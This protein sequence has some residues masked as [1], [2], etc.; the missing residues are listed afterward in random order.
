VQPTCKRASL[1]C[2]SRDRDSRY[3]L[4]TPGAVR[5]G[6]R[7]EPLKRRRGVTS[8]SGDWRVIGSDPGQST[9]PVLTQERAFFI[10]GCENLFQNPTI[11]SL[12]Q[13]LTGASNTSCQAEREL[14]WHCAQEAHCGDLT[15]KRRRG[16]LKRKRR[17][18]LRDLQEM[19]C[20][21]R[22]GYRRKNRA[23]AGPESFTCKIGDL[24]EV[25]GFPAGT[26]PA[27]RLCAR[28][29]ALECSSHR[30]L[31]SIFR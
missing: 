9:D 6:R 10:P 1:P 30:N 14:L 23:E 13:T 3:A 22:S 16:F 21:S 31:R 29:H 24:G 19:G 11:F 27:H 2:Q 12:N 17:N 18:H 26:G 20:E 5:H 8:Q 15:R 7:T 4:S 25:L 28:S